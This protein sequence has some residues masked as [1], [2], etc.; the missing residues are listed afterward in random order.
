[1]YKIV[2]CD[3]NGDYLNIVKEQ[4]EVYCRKN[5][6]RIDLETFQDSSRLEEAVEKGKLF[7]ACILDIDMPL[8]TGIDIADLVRDRCS[9]VFVI[10]LTAYSDYAGRACRVN[11]IR[12]VLK[13]K[14]EEELGEALDELFFRL[15]RLKCHK[16]YIISN[17]RKYIKLFQ[18][19]IIYICKR[20]K[21]VIFVMNDG[22][23]ER[24][25]A[26]LQDVYKRLNNPEMV[27]LDRGIILNLSHVQKVSGGRIEMKGGY[28]IITNT[29]HMMELKRHLTVYWGGMV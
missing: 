14:M 5:D 10:F 16:T 23:E 2:L 6:I 11:V 12:Y 4:V 15:E 29:E 3:D 18:K 26:T 8:C 25:R 13:E 20:Q 22:K 7:D 27:W 24:E 28:K 19:D 17:N 21:D 9:N 1:M